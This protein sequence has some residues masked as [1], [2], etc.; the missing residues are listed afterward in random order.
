MSTYGPFL[1]NHD[2]VPVWSAR[3]NF[4]SDSA[5]TLEGDI[6]TLKNTDHVS[7]LLEVMNVESADV[8]KHISFW[9]CSGMDGSDAALIEPIYF[10]QKDDDGS[11]T[12]GAMETITDGYFDISDGGHCTSAEDYNCFLFEFDGAEIWQEGVD[13]SAVDRSNDCFYAEMGSV[14]TTGS[15][16][17]AR[18]YYILGQPSLRYSNPAS[19][20]FDN[21]SN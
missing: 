3:Y 15:D 16:V 8:D 5:Y 1:Q 10:R 19:T 17:I 18:A 14:D 6:I 13:S 7:V 12:W 21:R 2:I 4:G 11:D 20:S 9:S